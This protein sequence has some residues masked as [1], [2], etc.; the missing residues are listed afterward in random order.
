M[1]KGTVDFVILS[2]V[3]EEQGEFDSIGIAAVSNGMF[4]LNCVSDGLL[5]G[6]GM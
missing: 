4:E 1:I 2:C 6:G 3:P 5:V